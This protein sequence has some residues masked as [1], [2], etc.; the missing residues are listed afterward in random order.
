MGEGPGDRTYGRG[1]EQLGVGTTDGCGQQQAQ[2]VALGG[3][4]SGAGAIVRVPLSMVTQLLTSGWSSRASTTPASLGGGGRAVVG[5][6]VEE[7]VGHGGDRGGV[8]GEEITEDGRLGRE[9]IQQQGPADPRGVGDVVQG[10]GPVA[11]AP[12]HLAGRSEDRRA[13]P[14]TL[15]SLPSTR[16]P[17]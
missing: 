13:G 16:A 12:E 11:A 9:V 14:F 6:G 7:P 8:A 3:E 2:P 5:C 10:R 17:S 4:E 1:G 15:M